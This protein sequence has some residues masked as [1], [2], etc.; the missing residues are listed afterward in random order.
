MV[1]ENFF[2]FSQIECIEDAVLVGGEEGIWSLEEA[3]AGEGGM[4]FF[5]FEECFGFLLGFSFP[6]E[7][8]AGEVGSDG[9][10]IGAGADILDGGLMLAEA[11]IF[12][13][14]F[15]V[16]YEAGLVGSDGEEV[17]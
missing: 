5:H 11:A 17:A 2:F 6:D 13:G 15:Q 4:F 16:H 12:F 1:F 3:D 14:V 8:F 9:D 7:D 10:V